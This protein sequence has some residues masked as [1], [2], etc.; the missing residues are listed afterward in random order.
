MSERDQQRDDKSNDAPFSLPLCIR[1]WNTALGDS[2]DYEGHTAI[3][4]AKGDQ[5]CEW[6]SASDWQ[7]EVASL[8][9]DSINAGGLWR[10]GKFQS[11]APSSADTAITDAQIISAF[12]SG[13]GP[14]D[15][16][17]TR[18]PHAPLLTNEQIIWVVRRF[19]A[20][21]VAPSAKGALWEA[22][23]I[24]SVSMLVSYCQ[25]KAAYPKTEWGVAFELLE[26]AFAASSASTAATPQ[27]I[28]FLM[29]RMGREGEH[30][31]SILR[32]VREHC[33]NVTNK[34]PDREKVD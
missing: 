21:S 4:D 3:E 13:F 24:A 34:V 33:E 26:Q 5:L 15:Q 6:Y 1:H 20:G 29:Q 10:Q 12:S 28:L 11:F 2:G 23:K 9:V 7:E 32:A 19:I 14:D 22:R 30:P 27:S 16:I 18:Q 17:P 8:I 25:Q 31:L